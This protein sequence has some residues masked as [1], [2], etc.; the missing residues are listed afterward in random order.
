[1][2][3]P[4]HGGSGNPDEQAV[5]ELVR[6]L[7]R[8]ENGAPAEGDRRPDDILAHDY[9]PITRASGAVDESRQ[10]HLDR[11]ANPSGSLT[12]DAENATIDVSLFLEG[13]VAIARTELPTTDPGKTPADASFRNM[14]V[15]LKRE[16]EWKC[17]AWQVT[18]IS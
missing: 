15:F 13:Q 12:R 11:I 16:G 8:A 18:R 5:R 1:M 14:Q 2:G 9:L 17:V 3:A 10:A 6:S 7:F 4:A